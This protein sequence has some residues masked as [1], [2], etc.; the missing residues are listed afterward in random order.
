MVGAHDEVISVKEAKEY[1]GCMK[2]CRFQSLEHL[3]HGLGGLEQG[4]MIDAVVRFLA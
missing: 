1:S 4:E 2:N 3:D